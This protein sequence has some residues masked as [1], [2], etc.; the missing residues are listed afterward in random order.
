VASCLKLIP[1]ARAMS[2]KRTGSEIGG[3]GAD[4][5]DRAVARSRAIEMPPNAKAATINA[6]ATLGAGAVRGDLFPNEYSSLARLSLYYIPDSLAASTAVGDCWYF[7]HQLSA[8]SYQLSAIS[9]QLSLISCQP[10]DFLTFD[11]RLFTENCQ[12]KTE[13]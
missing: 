11:F 7:S 1:A 3:P 6:G 9:S 4:F 10:F 8:I 5:T 12:L 13:N 2:V